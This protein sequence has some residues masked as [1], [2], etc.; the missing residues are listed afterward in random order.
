MAIGFCLLVLPPVS[1]VLGGEDGP[2][3]VGG[4]LGIVRLNVSV[5]NPPGGVFGNATRLERRVT[6]RR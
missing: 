4:L 6:M 5:T 1:K 2:D 3:H